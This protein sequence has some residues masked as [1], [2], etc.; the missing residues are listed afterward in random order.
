MEEPYDEIHGVL[1]GVP[2]EPLVVR[3]DS[4]WGPFE[5]PLLYDGLVHPIP[6][7]TLRLNDGPALRFA[8][9]TDR[10]SALT[11]FKW[12]AVKSKLEP[13]H[14]ASNVPVPLVPRRTV[15]VSRVG[16]TTLGRQLLVVP[17]VVSTVETLD[18]ARWQAEGIAGTIGTQFLPGASLRLDLRA[19]K[20]TVNKSGSQDATSSN[21]VAIALSEKAGIFFAAASPGRSAPQQDFLVNTG[22]PYVV[23]TADVSAKMEAQQSCQF[24]QANVDRG[25]IVAPRPVL[26]P[27]IECSG[28]QALSVA[29]W[30]KRGADVPLQLGCSFLD[31]FVVTI[32][33]PRKVMFLE[34]LP[35]VERSRMY[36]GGAF[37]EV[38]PS[39]GKWVIGRV[40]A[41]SPARRA[42]LRP[43]QEVRSVDGTRLAG[44]TARQVQ[45]LVVGYAGSICKLEVA[46]RDGKAHLVTFFRESPYLDVTPVSDK[47]AAL[48]QDYDGRWYVTEVGRR[49]PAATA[50]L[51]S[52]D[53]ILAI[54]GV[55][56]AMM[57]DDDIPR[58]FRS[59]A[60]TKLRLRV[61][62][63]ASKEPREVTLVTTDPP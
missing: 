22:S 3:A 4:Q 47:R 45:S 61:L 60:G 31:R 14:R 13:D 11:I 9:S 58:R 24:P 50:G 35:A 54:D 44:L 25:G 59:R 7:V 53:Q 63:V 23:V 8:Y 15:R 5:I 27:R 21:S 57:D 28:A 55:A 48:I 52:G 38:R 30:V 36:P 16:I 20:L 10:S 56:V 6:L 51:R 12:A 29:A 33:F 41:N 37:L 40:L 42:G 26:L 1:S 39:G 43:G 19:R 17:D 18:S 34:P 62:P 46:R 49:S 32:D 2:T